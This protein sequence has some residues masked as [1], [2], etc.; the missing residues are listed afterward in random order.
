MPLAC[1]YVATYA[2]GR[3]VD[4]EEAPQI[5]RSWFDEWRLSPLVESAL[6]ERGLDEGA[7]AWQTLL[8]KVLIAHQRWFEVGTARQV[9]ES[10]LRDGDVR[11]LIQV[12]RYRGVLWFNKEAF[13]ELLDWLLFVAVI[14][15]GAD[16]EQSRAFIEQAKRAAAEAGYRVERMLEM[17]G[18]AT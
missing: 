14:A 2:L 13:E 16:E 3:V 5:T 4:E 17:V 10:L 9:L 8:L 11:Y 15:P 1:L 7:A 12:N 6:R 18:E